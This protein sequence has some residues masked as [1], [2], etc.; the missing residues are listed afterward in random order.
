MH[1]YIFMIDFLLEQIEIL[2]KGMMKQRNSKKNI[3]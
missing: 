3:W 1:I 2:S